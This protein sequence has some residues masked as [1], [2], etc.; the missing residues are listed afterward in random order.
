MAQNIGIDLGTA[1]VLI[2][3]QGKGIEVNEPSVVAID[4]STRDIL[5]VGE[6][7][8]MMVGRTPGNIEIIRPL[9]GGVISDFDTTAAMLTSFIERLNIRR[10]F[11]KP[12][13]LIS[14]PSGVTSIEQRAIIEAAE[15]ASGGKVYLEEEPKVAAV[16]AGL[17][18]FQPRGNMV[19]D[20]G[21]GTSDAAV[22]SM[23]RIVTSQSIKTAGNA[24]DQAITQGIKNEYNLIIG[25]RTAED[26]K[27]NIG[28][29]LENSGL[30]PGEVR[31]RD[32]VTGL[33]RTITIEPNFVREQLMGPVL[34]IIEA[35]KKVLEETQPELSA[36]IIDHGIVLTGG[37]A[38]V[39]GLPEFFAEELKVPVFLA[40][41]PLSAVVLGTETMLENLA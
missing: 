9:A 12:N 31:G 14:A 15:K 16:G 21:G 5:A 28:T 36:D 20:I 23:G 35:A 27:K 30:E 11:T 10:L 3:V 6:E 2:Y 26:I 22:L 37:G 13:V 29:I 8:Y 19:V 38:L 18:I 7:A 33:P 1:N 40:E 4:A 39:H 24:F 41:Q 32:M 25:E 17:D 34:E